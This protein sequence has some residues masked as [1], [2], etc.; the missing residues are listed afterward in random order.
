MET[1]YFRLLCHAYLRLCSVFSLFIIWATS[2][3][4]DRRAVNQMDYWW[5]FIRSARLLFPPK[6]GWASVNV[7]AKHGETIRS[8][9]P[10]ETWHADN[11]LRVSPPFVIRTQQKT[12]IREIAC[13]RHSFIL[14]QQ[15]S[16]D[17]D[18]KALTRIR[19]G[20]FSDSCELKFYTYVCV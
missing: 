17:G 14:T 18:S 15:H 9:K 2:I 1:N 3:S 10:I 11:G 16:F 8:V 12:L 5:K 20:L 4:F 7:S 19:G 13:L 6:D